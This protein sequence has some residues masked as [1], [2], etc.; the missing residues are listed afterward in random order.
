MI[1]IPLC[2][3]DLLEE[4]NPSYLLHN[5]SDNNQNWY[6]G[7]FFVATLLLEKCEDDIHTPEMG[8]WESSKTL[9]TSEFDYRGQKTSP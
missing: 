7:A 6:M 3:Y 5:S 2:K 4:N 8:T 1:L 9:E